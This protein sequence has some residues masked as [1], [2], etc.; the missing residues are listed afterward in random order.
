M[1]NVRFH[2]ANEVEHVVNDRGYEIIYLQPFSPFLNLI[3]NM[4]NRLKFYVKRTSPA[5]ADEV[6]SAVENASHCI[7]EQDCQNYWQ[8]MMKYVVR[9]LLGEPIMN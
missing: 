7:S 3:E 2:H 4:F 6:F 9:S 8:N 5:N 1:D